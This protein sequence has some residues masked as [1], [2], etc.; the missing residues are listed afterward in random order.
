MSEITHHDAQLNDEGFHEIQLSG[1]QL[2]F[3]FMATATVL[4]VTFL[5]GVQVG[6]NVKTPDRPADQADTL[7]SAGVPPPAVAVPSQPAAASS[8]PPA[9]ASG[10]ASCRPCDPGPSASSR[11]PRRRR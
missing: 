3:L 8:G 1:K 11:S 10:D 6:R 5:C 2:V 4:V 9:S 7:A